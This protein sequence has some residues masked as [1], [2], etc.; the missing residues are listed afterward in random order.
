MYH[1]SSARASPSQR[2]SYHGENSFE[3]GVKLFV[4]GLEESI[5]HKQLRRLFEKYGKV[6]SAYV[7]RKLKRGRRAKFGFVLFHHR[8]D[9][10][11][12]MNDL[13]G[14]RLNN[15][16]LTINPARFIDRKFN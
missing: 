10:L 6:I 8:K 2:R 7:P 14:K 4:D 13:H 3:G 5:C 9:G 16:F 12:A 11:K 1:L 15:T